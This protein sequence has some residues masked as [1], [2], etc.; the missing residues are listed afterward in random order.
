MLNERDAIDLDAVVKSQTEVLGQRAL[1]RAVEAGNPDP[2]LVF[3]T[4]IHGSLHLEQQL[5]E[6]LIDAV[7]HH[8]LGDLGLETCLLRDAIGDDLFDAAVNVFAGVEKLFDFHT[9]LYSLAADMYRAVV[10]VL[11]IKTEELQTGFASAHAGIEKHGRHMEFA[12]QL[13]FDH[14]DAHEGMQGF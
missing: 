9:C 5:V 14:S 12:L 11:G 6:L 10:T 3:T 13:P 7:S 4:C 2:H 8:I 1:T